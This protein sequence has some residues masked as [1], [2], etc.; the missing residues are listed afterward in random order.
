MKSIILI[1]V[2]ALGV[3]VHA[4][5][6]QFIAAY[7]AGKYDDAAKQIDGLDTSKPGVARRLGVMYYD[8]RGVA[9]DQVKGRDLLEAAMLG[10]DATAAINLAK[11]Y[12][13]LEK[14]S[15]SLSGIP[16]NEGYQN[17]RIIRKVVL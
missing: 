17:F 10:G 1:A 11:I 5:E 7:D 4:G 12:F 6:S 3:A 9:G 16:D 8:G 2:A 14:N 15:P 13:K